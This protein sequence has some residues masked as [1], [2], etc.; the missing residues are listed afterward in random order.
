MKSCA[1]ALLILCSTFAIAAQSGAIVSG[2]VTDHDKPVPNH[3]I[4]LTAPDGTAVR[5]KTDAGG[6]FEFRGV[7][8]GT[9]RVGGRIRAQ[10][11]DLTVVVAGSESVVADLG[12]ESLT[13]VSTSIV[14]EY[15]SISTDSIEPVERVSK[16][17]SVI[18]GREMRERADFSLVESLR[19]VPGF[20]VQQ[21]GGFGRT[22]SVKSRGLRNQDTAVL[23]DGIRF[24][25]ASSITGDA[26]AFLGDITLTS[27]SRVEILRGPGSSLYGTNA[28][29]GTID[30]QSAEPQAGWRGQIGGALGGLGLGRFRGNL[31]KG[32]LGGA[33][34]F[35]SGIS[36][37]VYTK[38]VDGNDDARNTNFQTRV[39][40]KPASRTSVSGR[41][42]YSDAF[43]ALNTGPDTLGA[44]PATNAV[45]LTAR[46]GVNFAPDA[47]DPDSSQKSRFFN[48]QIGLTHSFSNR[49]VLDAFFSGLTTRRR[50]GNGSLGSG[51]QSASTSIF[52]GGIR[53][54]GVKLN[55]IAATDQNL[56]F[57]YEFE[58]ES[59]RNEG[60]T[61]SGSGN[62]L[63]RAGQR[64]Q[65]VF[66]QHITRFLG[67]RLN[68][69]GGVRGQ[70][71]SLNAPEF[72]R[73]NAPYQGLALSEPPGAVTVD[74]SVSYYFD[75]TG[76][77]IR[78]HMG[79]GYRV[80]SLYERFGT[81]YSSFSSAF[82][83]LGDPNLKPEKTVAFDAGIDQDLFG[84]KLRMSA[85]YFYTALD[86]TIGFGNV[87][88]NFGSTTRPFGGYLN[89]KGGTAR[90]GE[91]SAGFK[92]T[93]LTEITASYTYTASRQRSPA[94]TG[95]P[96][97]KTLGVPDH[98][99]TL[100]A[101]QRFR[102]FWVN[103][104]FLATSSYLAP[105]FSNSSFRTFVY[106]F[107]G[108][109]RADLTAGY[110]F[111]LKNERFSLRLF[112][113]VENMLDDEYYENGFRT[114]G[115]NGRIGLSFG[116]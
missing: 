19:T 103:F 84:K 12:F 42:F 104:D 59:F 9:Y 78:A 80:P 50:N 28:I 68:V 51:F 40:W 73:S 74:G 49:F 67:G 108:N 52:E 20:R 63:T 23:L 99:F 86:R 35:A 56:S 5:T 54:G 8:P 32:L 18:E 83:A 90:G 76:T 24:R 98:Q 30:F 15:V 105:I 33:F 92:P 97:L 29:G 34:G 10:S 37:T 1:T 82:F 71:F 21:L 39:Q 2:T 110:N 72:S 93:E 79:N 3:E 48:G 107:E 25:D 47:D 106:R 91:F 109:R 60:F 16:S 114:A 17:V 57:G 31:S 22:A 65:T 87:V 45:T 53:T 46:P 81:F 44:L 26:S 112:G 11:V 58:D 62:F 111:R 66:A 75:R 36:R 116:F 64:S 69:A 94:V 101:T 7:A 113:T 13:S 43:V 95:N 70:F 14:R 100:V 41:I 88:P 96:T 89:T 6:R 38:G 4:E 85:V 77:K 55:W 102:E 27:V 115:I 61:P